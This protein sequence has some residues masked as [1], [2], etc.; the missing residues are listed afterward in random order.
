MKTSCKSPA[1]LLT[2]VLLKL[3]VELLYSFGLDAETEVGTHC[4]RKTVKLQSDSSEKQSM[5]FR[6]DIYFKHC[7][8]LKIII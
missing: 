5:H 8:S 4:N 3:H 7:Y 6:A 1:W 2:H